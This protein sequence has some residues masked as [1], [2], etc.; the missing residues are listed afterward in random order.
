MQDP[1]KLLAK[2]VRRLRTIGTDTQLV[3]VKEAA[4]KLPESIGETLSAFMNHTGGILIL[5]LSERRGFTPVEGFN[6]RRL[7]NALLSAC[8][9]ITPPCRPD[10][11]SRAPKFVAAVIPALEPDL[12]PAYIT[13]RGPV[14]GSFIRT[15]TATS[16]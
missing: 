6:A 16:D 13:D 10:S 9:T 8:D 4:W 12:R 15:A 7:H 2:I 11:R 14:A 5:G 1:N 3:E